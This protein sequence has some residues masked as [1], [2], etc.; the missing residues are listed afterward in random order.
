MPREALLDQWSQVARDG[1][2]TSAIARPRVSP[3]AGNLQAL[4][5]ALTGFSRQESITLTQLA[6]LTHLHGSTS[7]IETEKPPADRCPWVETSFHQDQIPPCRQ[8][9]VV[10]YVSVA[11]C[12]S[13]Q[14]GSLAAMLM[15]LTAMSITLGTLA[16]AAR[17][18]SHPAS[19]RGGP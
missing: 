9:C 10:A 7:N 19:A 5:Q 16:V 6:S 14:H 4:M 3:H 13:A 2:F 11:L 1:S 18:C 8:K 12:K 17:L 15:A